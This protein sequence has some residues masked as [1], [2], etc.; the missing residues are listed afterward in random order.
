MDPPGNS[1]HSPD[2]I[3]EFGD[4]KGGWRR[5]TVDDSQEIFRIIAMQNLLD[6]NIHFYSKLCSNFLSATSIY[7]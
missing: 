5:Q 4:R 3:A 1:K 6:K 7:D 2:P